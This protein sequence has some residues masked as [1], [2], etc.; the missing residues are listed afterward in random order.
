[1]ILQ[2]KHRAAQFN[3]LQTSKNAGNFVSWYCETDQFIFFTDKLKTRG[4]VIQRHYKVY[5]QINITESKLA[6]QCNKF[7]SLKV[8]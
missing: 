5:K 1:M 3:S 7:Y 4:T 8:F 6:N 2:A